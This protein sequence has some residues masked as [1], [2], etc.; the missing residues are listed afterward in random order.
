[1]SDPTADPTAEETAPEATEPAETEPT[2]PE[3]PDDDAGPS[4]QPTEGDQ[5]DWVEQMPAS[6]NPGT[7]TGFN[8]DRPVRTSPPDP[9][10]QEGVARHMSGG[11]NEDV[12]PGGG[13]AETRPVGNDQTDGEPAE[14]E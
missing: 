12:P 6:A 3:H 2:S 8:P 10:Q 14:H 4:V 5:G 1:M 11:G 9:S 7:D 13:D